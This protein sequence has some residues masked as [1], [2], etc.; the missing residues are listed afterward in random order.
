M[1]WGA[2]KKNILFISSWY[3]NRL[4]STNGN[5]V[6]RHAE[7]ISLLHFVEVLHCIGDKNQQEKWIIDDRKINGI[8]TLIVYYKKSK[9]PIINFIRRMKGYKIGFAQLKKPD[10]VHANILQNQSLFAVYLKKKWQIPFVI[11]EHWSGLL[12]INANK[13]SLSKKWLARLVASYSSAVLPVSNNLAKDMK[14]AGI[15]KKFFIVENVVDTDIFKPCINE[16]KET[17]KF[18]FLHISNLVTLKNPEKII[19]VA[20]KLRREFSN[21]ELQI[22]GDGDIERLKKEIKKNNAQEYI[23][24]FGEIKTNEVATKMQNA[25][26]FLLYSD[27][28][29]LPCVLLESMSCGTPVIATNVGGISEIVNSNCGELIKVEE[30]ELYTAMKTMLLGNKIY[31]SKQEMHQYIVDNFSKLKIAE[32][33]DTVY[34][35]V[36]V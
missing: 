19:N 30:K 7:A 21:F 10:L 22:G 14:D 35:N 34:K 11:S 20:A 6:Q 26:C 13:L 16:N 17:E 4:E 36:L 24:V 32:K 25:D 1:S 31:L 5:F 3:P 28:E 2:S 27:Y 23:S 12:K 15:G 33:I 8:R 9:Y 18:V 29:N